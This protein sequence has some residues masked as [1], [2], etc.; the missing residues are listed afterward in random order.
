F[1]RPGEQASGFLTKD[2]RFVKVRVPVGQE[3]QQEDSGKRTD[4]PN[5]TVPRTPY[6]NAPLKEGPPDQAQPKQ[7]IPLEYRNILQK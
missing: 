6:S 7:P 4:N 1:L 5:T 3:A 2:A